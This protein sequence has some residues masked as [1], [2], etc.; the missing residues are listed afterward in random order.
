MTPELK[1]KPSNYQ[2]LV[3]EAALFRSIRVHYHEKFGG[4]TKVI[5]VA[6]ASTCPNRLGLKGMQTCI[7][8]DEWGSAAY[9]DTQHV[10]FE[11]QVKQRIGSFDEK[12]HTENYLVYFQAYTNTFLSIRKLEEH[13]KASEAYPQI[14]GFILGTRPDCLSRK[15]LDVLQAHAKKRY[16]SI[17]LGVQSFDNDQLGFLRRG[18]S[19]E[20]SIEAIELIGEREEIEV[21]IHLMFGVPGETEDQIIET[22]R[23][24]SRLPVNHV[25]LH[26]LHVLKNTPL[27]DLYASGE[28]QPDSLDTYTQKVTLFLQYLR[29]GI[30]VQRLVALSSRWEELVAPDWTKHKLKTR[31]YIV[32]SLKQ[33]KAFQGQYY[34]PGR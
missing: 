21:G 27:E 33:N 11:E 25:K 30:V 26:N 14:K 16:V 6:V 34:S 8:C 23:L 12:Y 18:H 7:F 4:R 20:Q 1:N 5:P 19:R 28:F 32:D 10:P 17:E 13:I 3:S 15:F 2:Q 31:N 24:V 29:P 22:A 9:T